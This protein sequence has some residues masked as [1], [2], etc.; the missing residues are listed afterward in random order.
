M[1]SLG[2]SWLG[3]ALAYVTGMA[4]T[5][6]ATTIRQFFERLLSTATELL[7]NFEQGVRVAKERRRRFISDQTGVTPWF[8]RTVIDGVPWT[9][10]TVIDAE[11]YIVGPLLGKQ[12][13]ASE[14]SRGEAREELYAYVE[15]I[16]AEAMELGK[17]RR[18][19][20]TA[21]VRPT[22]SASPRYRTTVVDRPI[23]TRA[24]HVA[25]LLGTGAAIAAELVRTHAP[26][27]AAQARAIYERLRRE[28]RARPRETRLTALFVF[29]VMIPLSIWIIGSHDES[30]AS[31]PTMSA[32]AVVPDLALVPVKVA[33]LPTRAVSPSE[34]PSRGRRSWRS[35]N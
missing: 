19:A 23:R 15:K 32:E 20:S 27:V 31:T 22:R 16:V 24:G 8:E 11:P 5:R 26:W 4:R 7:G 18:I 34:K 28:I 21:A 14:I 10:C 30:A 9:E 25:E 29:C 33:P 17:R 1:P 2:L 6:G 13:R 35:Q 3:S 12:P